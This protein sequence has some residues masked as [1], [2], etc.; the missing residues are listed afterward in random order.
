MARPMQ[1]WYDIVG[2]ARRI[3]IFGDSIPATGND[4]STVWP[5]LLRSS[6]AGTWGRGGEG[7]FGLW[8]PEWS[9]LS[10]AWTQAIS[11]D[12]WDQ[13]PWGKAETANGSGN[14]RRYTIP[15]FVPTPI[16]D[17]EIYYVD[18]ASAAQFSV[19]ADG[20]AYVN[21]SG[22]TYSGAN[23]A[24]KLTHTV[25]ASST[26]DVRAANA[27]GTGV[28]V[29]LGGIAPLGTAGQLVI[30]NLGWPAIGLANLV[31]RKITPFVQ[32]TDPDL[33]VVHESNDAVVASEDAWGPNL[34][35]IWRACPN[36]AK[37]CIVNGEQNNN[38]DI[39]AQK[40]Y[41]RVNRVIAHQ[42]NAKF[43]D[44]YSY[45]GTQAQGQAS[46]FWELLGVH[47]STD[48]YIDMAS[49]IQ[50]VLVDTHHPQF[51]VSA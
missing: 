23:Q 30:D 41:R 36:A 37:L 29:Y 40:R 12:A 46:G 16:A 9:V 26:I 24:R 17:I 32:L 1:S 11:S 49:R 22:G 3:L 4:A 42:Y 28:A 13:F 5:V 31:G 33:V 35:T 34:E 48:G 38:R 27:A 19:S 43:M 44:F 6:L 8:R 39:W 47:P 51:P 18:G 20:G 10:G 2:S 15:S 21:V 14:V 50:T 7:Y 45:W 25:N